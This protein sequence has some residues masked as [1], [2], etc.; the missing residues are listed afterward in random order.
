MQYFMKSGP[1]STPC[2]AAG[3]LKLPLVFK[4]LS[5]QLLLKANLHCSK[6]SPLNLLHP[7]QLSNGYLAQSMLPHASHRCPFYTIHFFQ[8][9]LLR[10]GSYQLRQ[11]LQE[12]KA[13]WQ[14]SLCQ[15]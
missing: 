9:C 1:P 5:N 13:M 6:G 3:S 14:S 7:L 4:V 15:C 10:S 12:E 8:L 2:K 11:M